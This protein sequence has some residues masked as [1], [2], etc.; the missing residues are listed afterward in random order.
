[1]AELR[2]T[3]AVLKGRPKGLP[4][5]VWLVGGFEPGS[6]AIVVGVNQPSVKQDL[7]R[8]T[9]SLLMRQDEWQGGSKTRQRVRILGCF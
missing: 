4:E 1:M 5:G 3:V 6:T 2:W 9:H 7:K 8:P